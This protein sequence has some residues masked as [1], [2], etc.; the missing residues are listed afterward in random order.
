MEREI[1]MEIEKESQTE[2]GDEKSDR[3]WSSPA[4]Q[5]F[6]PLKRMDEKAMRMERMEKEVKELKKDLR[7]EAK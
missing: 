5:R 3:N 2:T 4:C 1:E 7:E 6:S